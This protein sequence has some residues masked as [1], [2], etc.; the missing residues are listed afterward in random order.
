MNWVIRYCVP[1]AGT[2]LVHLDVSHSDDQKKNPQLNSPIN[3]R[4]GTGLFRWFEL[5]V[6]VCSLYFLEN[7]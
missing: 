1:Q 4:T 2:F 3:K 5:L 6:Q 7:L